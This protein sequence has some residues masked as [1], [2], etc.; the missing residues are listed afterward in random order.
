MTIAAMLIAFW[1]VV[2]A[3]VLVMGR[4]PRPTWHEPVA[5]PFECFPC[6]ARYTSALSLAQH[7]HA[8]HAPTFRTDSIEVLR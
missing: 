3:I 6:R 4:K 7:Q 2:L 1:S 8:H 5:R